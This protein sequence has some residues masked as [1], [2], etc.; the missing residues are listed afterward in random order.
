M[1]VTI[2]R[3]NKGLMGGYKAVGDAEANTHV[4]LAQEDYEA[5]VGHYSRLVD[6]LNE[7]ITQLTRE[8]A[9]LAQKV[10]AY[11]RMV[12]QKDGELNETRARMK[13][14]AAEAEAE[15]AEANARNENLMRIIRERANAARDLRPK[16]QRSGYLLLSVE[17]CHYR[18][19]REEY[20]AQKV[21]LQSPYP[22]AMET[23]VARTTIYRDLLEKGV[24]GSMGLTQMD[25]LSGSHREE[26]EAKMKYPELEAELGMG[27]GAYDFRFKCN[28]QRGYWEVE[29]LATRPITVPTDLLPG[30]SS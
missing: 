16:K 25:D 13:E 5:L 4:I 23:E 12:F 17:D 21:R 11:S 26:I 14:A 22:A 7:K 27:N 18:K 10:S 28:T 1:D 8:K 19:N 2:I 15:I 6:D 29:F 30:K 3:A 9:Q 24:G 20:S